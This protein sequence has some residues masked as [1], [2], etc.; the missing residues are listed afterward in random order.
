[1]KMQSTREKYLVTK[2]GVQYKHCTDNYVFTGQ[3]MWSEGE[4]FYKLFKWAQ[5]SS[6]WGYLKRDYI[7]DEGDGILGPL[8]YPIDE[9][10]IDAEM[11][12]N[13]I[14]SYFLKKE[15]VPF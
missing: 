5:N 6:W 8:Y 12:A 3:G 7:G 11:L 10:Y 4:Y 1:M 13:A 14:Y 2:M 15:E 9:S